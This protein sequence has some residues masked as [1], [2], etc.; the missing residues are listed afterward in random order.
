MPKIHCLLAFIFLFY[1]TLSFGDQCEEIAQ[2]MLK[3]VDG[4]DYSKPSL[5]TDK[6]VNL[7]QLTNSH[8]PIPTSH[9]AHSS[10]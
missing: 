7:F 6:S 10:H 8:L 9:G 3:A 4:G 2:K 5:G 1:S